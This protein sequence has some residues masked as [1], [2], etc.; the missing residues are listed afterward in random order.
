MRINSWSEV[1]LDKSGMRKL[2]RGAGGE[3]ARKTRRLI[4]SSAGS[5]RP[6]RGGGGAAYRG[7]Y[8]PGSYRASAAGEPPV[9]V[10]GALAKSLRVYPYKSGD[11]FAVR[12]RQFYALF[13]E[14]G[15]SGGGNPYGGRRSAGTRNPAAR[16]H[17]ARGRYTVRR[18]EPRPFLDR[19]MK[20]EEANLER[21]VDAAM[22]DGLTWK[23][24]RGP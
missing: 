8:R 21:R 17:R 11:G 10:S 15:A 20:Q 4:A 13:L 22:K 7:S 1:A 16:R 3:V 9:R 24:T 2:M 5:G 6:Y 19:V 18:L 14:V 23:A 12:A